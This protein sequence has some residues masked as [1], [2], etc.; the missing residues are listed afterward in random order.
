MSMVQDGLGD[1]KDA[2]VDDLA[3]ASYSHAR[4]VSRS[5]AD[6]C[7]MIVAGLIVTLVC[8]LGIAVVTIINIFSFASNPPTAATS[9]TEQRDFQGALRT[10]FLSCGFTMVL[11]AVNVVG[12]RNVLLGVHTAVRRVSARA[13]T[14]VRSS[15]ASTAVRSSVCH[16]HLPPPSC[17]G[18]A[19]SCQVVPLPEV[20]LRLRREPFVCHLD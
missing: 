1:Y 19:P 12:F 11:F 20:L 2:G 17:D 10:A 13:S 9:Y 7:R 8:D 18:S 15:R 14:H 6:G 3:S 5:F 16:Q 4:H